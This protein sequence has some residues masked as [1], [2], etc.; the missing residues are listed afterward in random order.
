MTDSFILPSLQMRQ[1]SP[2]RP[3]E[4]SILGRISDKAN[5]HLLPCVFYA[6]SSH[7]NTDVPVNYVYAEMTPKEADR[8]QH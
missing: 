8:T 7:L 3:V 2:G 4:P 5:S 6:S 1:L